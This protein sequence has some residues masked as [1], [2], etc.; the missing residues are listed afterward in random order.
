MNK[1]IAI[2][3]PA[4]SHE[5]IRIVYSIDQME[6]IQTIQCNVS[7]GGLPLWLQLRKFSI[8][9]RETHGLY[10]RLYS[11]DTN[12][13]IDTTLFIDTVYSSIMDHELFEHE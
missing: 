5:M 1:E 13:N 11:D 4:D 9:S 7:T 6:D 8:C 12:K 10:T 2:A 3:Y